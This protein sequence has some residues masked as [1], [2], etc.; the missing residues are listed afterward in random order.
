MDVSARY[1][2][3]ARSAEDFR[4]LLTDKKIGMLPR[5]ILGGGTN[6]LFTRDFDGLVIQNRI[7]GINKLDSDS[8]YYYVEAGAGELWHEFVMHCIKNNY[9]GVENLSLIPGSVGAAPIQNIGAYGVELKEVFHQVKAVEMQSGKAVILQKEEC[10][11]GYRDSIFKRHAKG[12]YIIT[13]VV[14][15]LTKAPKINTSYGAI[16][17]ELEK[18][19]VTQPTI[20][21]VSQAVCNIR[22]SK[23]PDPE[24]IGNAGSFFKN[25]TIPATQYEELKKDFPAI[26]AY[27]AGSDWKLAAGWLIEQCG[28]KGKR[29]GNTGV[30]TDQALVLVNY[31]NAKGKEVF[32]LSSEILRSVK[33]K[34]G[35]ELEREVVII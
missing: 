33:E 3:E 19:G 6:I 1:F 2:A 8:L 17:A 12:K 14:F 24:K 31:G 27:G 22:R 30:H 10:E 29:I 18:M 5:L 20:A 16:N 26:V 25:P 21:H 13:S 32:D 15:K 28:W 9:G 23:L 11:F 4:E 35:I 34:F 7:G